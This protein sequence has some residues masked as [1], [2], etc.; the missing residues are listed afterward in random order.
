[1]DKNNVLS[2]S[3]DADKLD[4][5]IFDWSSLPDNRRI[6]S[7]KICNETYGCNNRVLYNK[8]KSKIL[9]NKDI[10][11]K[12]YLLE[13]YDYSSIDRRDLIYR[14]GLAKTINNSDPLI[15][16]IY[17]YDIELI[18]DP[19]YKD[20]YKEEFLNIYNKFIR[21]SDKYQKYSNMYSVQLFGYNVRSMYQLIYLDIIS[22]NDNDSLVL[23]RDYVDSY[24]S[25]I[26]ESIVE[27]YIDKNIF[28]L[29]K[30]KLLHCMNSINEASTDSILFNSLISDINGRITQ[31]CFKDDI[32]G[33]VPYFTISEYNSI[34][35][36]SNVELDNTIYIE[37]IKS[38]NQYFKVIDEL[39]NKF[40]NSNKSDIVIENTLLSLG[41]NPYVDPRKYM[42]KARER[43]IKWFNEHAAHII[44]ISEDDNIEIKN[45]SLYESSVNMNNLYNKLNIY[46][47]YIILSYTNTTFG[48]IIR[49]VKS[50]TFTHAGIT[51]D[52][53]LEQILSFEFDDAKNKGFKV[54]SLN[55]YLNTYTDAQISVLCLFVDS[56]TIN[57]LEDSIRYFISNKNKTKYNFK[58]LINILR[59]KAKDNDYYNLSLV[60]SQFVDTILKLVDINITN[61]SSNLVIPQD[62]EDISHPKVYKLYNGLGR[63]YN[64]LKVEAKIELMLNTS[65]VEDIKY[66]DFVSNIQEYS[67]HVL[68]Y[69]RYRITDNDKANKILQELYN[70]IDPM[71]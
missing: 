66:S 56:N 59:N 57:K 40:I 25:A 1:M 7:D 41:W 28:S 46:P 11:I 36:D 17:P 38:S 53:N 71:K 16:I 6:I 54:E 5:D 55:D 52:S 24:T 21:L 34:L 67:N 8:L 10:N 33:A 37:D 39:Y 44:D 65:N 48:K 69:K 30:C 51:L 4:K 31:E 61:K 68:M 49:R 43:Q 22:N 29:Y 14:I 63:K 70:Y 2:I 35:D 19:A 32:V 27:D 15:A 18:S 47:V 60:C 45:K 58:N 26:E 20:S 12:S 23:S 64:E 62:F 50:S 9:F 13:S 42:S 3:F